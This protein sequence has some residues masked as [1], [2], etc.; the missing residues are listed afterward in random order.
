MS[1][2]QEM[3]TATTRKRNKSCTSAEL[4]VQW[5]SQLERNARDISRTTVYSTSHIFD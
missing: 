3:V 4:L 2:H 1:S 5:H